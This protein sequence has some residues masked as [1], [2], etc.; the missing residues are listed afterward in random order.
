[1]QAGR[2]GRCVRERW[3]RVGSVDE[4]GGQS[5]YSADSIHYPTSVAEVQQLVAHHRLVKALGTRHSFNTIADSPGGALISLSELA[6]DIA[7]D[8][9]A[10]TVSVTGGTRYGVLAAQ[11]QSQ[12]YALLSPGNLK[13]IPMGWIPFGQVQVTRAAQSA[14]WSQA[15]WS[16]D[17]KV[18]GPLPLGLCRDRSC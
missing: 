5:H 6:P 10:M 12:G 8:A 3:D 11:L 14:A 18:Y 15:G 9:E 4:L 2:A 16:A 1:M 17:L 13:A 7:V